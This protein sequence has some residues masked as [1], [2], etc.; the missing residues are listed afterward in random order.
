MWRVYI[1]PIFD[2]GCQLWSPID[3]SDIRKMEDV[4]RN[5]TAHAQKLSQDNEKLNFWQRISFFNISSQQRRQERFTIIYTWKIL[6]NLVPNCGLEWES[7]DR[8]G[9][10]CKIPNSSNE[11]SAKVKTIRNSSFQ[12]RGPLLFNTIPLEL[13]N[14]SNCSINTFKNRLD[15]LLNMI[16]DTPLTQKYY[17]I[18]L[19]RL[20]TRS[21]NS[22][23][24]WFQYLSIPNRRAESLTEILE[25]LK[26]SAT[27]QELKSQLNLPNGFQSHTDQ[28]DT[29]SL[30]NE[31]SFENSN[32]DISIYID[33]N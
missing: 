3:Q 19:N 15:C 2:Y 8:S 20:S 12:S 10:I 28:S 33:N 32:M 23:I 17:P 14:L 27:F 30:S 29:E 21:S 5:Y 16:P 11:T 4:L 26:E 25:N 13:R 24:E 31:E 1:Q 7:T 9:R 6:E 18:P 22:I